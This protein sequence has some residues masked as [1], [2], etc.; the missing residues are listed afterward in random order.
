VTFATDL[1]AFIDQQVWTF[2][3]TMPEWPH[4]YIVR[5]RVD[6]APFERL[7]E[8]IRD[9]GAEGRFYERVLTYYEEA[10]LVYWTMGA[11]L[12]ETT[13]VNRCRS[14]HTYERR[15]AEGRLP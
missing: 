9:H 3:K 1:R 12:H 6:Q 10:G 4:E 13:I 14:E 8:H 2:A 15:L 11:P 7:V 5:D